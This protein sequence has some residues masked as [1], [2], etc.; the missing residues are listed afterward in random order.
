MLLSACA[1]IIFDSTFDT[2]FYLLRL[3]DNVILVRHLLTTLIR[4]DERMTAGLVVRLYCCGLGTGECQFDMTQL[5]YVHGASDAPFIGDTI[6]VHFDRIVERFGERDALIVRHQAD[7]LD[8]PRAEGTGRRLCRRPAGARAQA[9]RPHRRVVAEQCRMGDHPIRDRQ[10]RADPRQHQSGLSPG[11]ARIRA[12]QG[13]LCR[14]DYRDAVQ[15]QRLSSRC[16]A[17]WRP[18]SPL[19]SPGN[20]HASRLP[21]SAAG[22]HHRR[23]YRPRHGAVR[24]CFRSRR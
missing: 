16:C 5:S 20:L 17:N 21:R 23:R 1:Q 22:D 14:P 13:R 6:G 7:P 3:D 12:E 19:Q 2:M 4:I 18:S 8:I 9:R 11:R 24:R 10:G 15:N